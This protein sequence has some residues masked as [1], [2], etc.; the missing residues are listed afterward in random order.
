M[1]ERLGYAAGRDLKLPL[2]SDFNADLPA[3][4]GN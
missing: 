4:P 1:I 2:D 3:P